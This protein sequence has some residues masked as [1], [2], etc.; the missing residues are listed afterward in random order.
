MT[1][2]TDRQ[3]R[4]LAR[5]VA[6]YIEQGEPVS[7]SWLAENSGLGVSS[8]TVRNIL[9]HLEES[10]LLRQPHTSAGR[11]PTEKGLRLFVDGM[12]QVGDLTREERA[13][14]V[15]WELRGSGRITRERVQ[16]LT[17]LSECGARALLLR[18]SRTLPFYYDP[19][20]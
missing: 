19:R 1:D 9:S 12:L 15:V 4:L 13:G 20:S 14:W 17:G 11:V 2:L 16:R 7:S 3:H 6:E 18:L 8:A 10:G 5:L